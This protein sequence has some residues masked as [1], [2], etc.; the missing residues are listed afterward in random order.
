MN[1]YI[2]K[3]PVHIKANS[4]YRI[5]VQS[6]TG[7]ESIKELLPLNSTS[8]LNERIPLSHHACHQILLIKGHIQKRSSK[9]ESVF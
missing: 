1:I 9:L 3:C 7:N 2:I 5:I 6:V 4:L 8:K